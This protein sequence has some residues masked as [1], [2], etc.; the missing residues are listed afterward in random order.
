[1]AGISVP[2]SLSSCSA[3]SLTSTGQIK[4]LPG[5]DAGVSPRRRHGLHKSQREFWSGP[6]AKMLQSQEP[7]LTPR[8]RVRT[9]LI[10]TPQSWRDRR[11][12]IHGVRL[13][14]NLQLRQTPCLWHQN[15]SR[16]HLHLMPWHTEVKCDVV[17]I[18]RHRS[19]DAKRSRRL[20]YCTTQ[21]TCRWTASEFP[22]TLSRHSLPPPPHHMICRYGSRMECTYAATVHANAPA[23]LSS[24]ASKREDDH[25]ASHASSR[26]LKSEDI[27]IDKVDFHSIDRL[28]Y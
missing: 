21:T 14:G 18:L 27:F 22:Q 1:M 28:Q 9:K 25:T 24:K 12:D 19:V 17:Q 15:C 5:Q 23:S 7:G 6:G 20:G 13:V 3:H 4:K 16:F 8:L 26:W 11:G 10:N 2:E